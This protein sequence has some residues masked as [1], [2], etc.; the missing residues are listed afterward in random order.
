MSEIAFLLNGEVTRVTDVSP[1]RTLLDW[2]REDRGLKGTKEGCNE[3]DCGACTVVITDEVG[4]RAMNACLVFLPTLQGRAVRTVEGLS[5]PEGEL[6]PV[7]QAMID[8]HGSQCG[9]CTPGIVASLAAG[10]ANGRRDHNDVLAGNLCRCTGYAP[11]VK[12]AQAVEGQPV[13]AWMK[14]DLSKLSAHKG[15]AGDW[16]RP[17]TPDDL[18]KWCLDHPSGRLVGGATDVGLWVNK[19]LADLGPVAFLC[20]VKGLDRIRIT[21]ETVRI[22]AGAT[23]EAVMHELRPL[24]PSFADMLRR[25]GS[26]QVRNTATIGG[27]IAN[28]S[29]IGDSAP[30]LIA[31]GATVHLRRGFERRDV[32]LENYFIAYGKQ[33]RRPGEFIEAI[34]FPRVADRLKCYKISK[35]FDQDISALLGCFNIRVI[36]GVVTSARIAFGGMDGIPRRARAVESTLIGKLWDKTAADNTE[37]AFEQD[38][39]PISDLRA[40]ATYRMDAARGLLQRYILEDLGAN[41][42][43]LRLMGG[44]FVVPDTQEEVAKAIE[45]KTG[46]D[47]PKTGAAPAAPAPVNADKPGEGKGDTSPAKPA[48]TDAAKADKPPAEPKASN[49]TEAAPKSAKPAAPAAKAKPTDSAPKT[50]PDA[51]ISRGEVE[52]AAPEATPKKPEATTESTDPPPKPEARPSSRERRAAKADT[53]GAADSPSDKPIAVPPPSPETKE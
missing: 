36:H 16:A 14:E 43:V 39:A 6:H 19:D 45:D 9:F 52:K 53:S 44:L 21:D 46:E 2:L 41:A 26:V 35:R 38:F 7:Q 37:R 27:N 11:I 8:H 32:L 18:A 15:E 49:S 20:D 40:G 22:G 3:G 31:L 42:Q 23:I 48:A 47:T 33:D 28:G 4:S 10:H 1:T 51:A 24:Y 17:E 5:G 30:A 34:S 25:Y 50:R 29:P 12:A 13:P